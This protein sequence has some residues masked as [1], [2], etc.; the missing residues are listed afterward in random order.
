[1]LAHAWKQE[2]PGCEK[3]ACSNFHVK[4]TVP[5]EPGYSGTSSMDSS[6]TVALYSFG[7][8]VWETSFYKMVKLVDSHAWHFHGIFM[9]PSF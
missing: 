3:K 7:L 8:F 4:M 2:R 6:V 9:A 1:V 5:G